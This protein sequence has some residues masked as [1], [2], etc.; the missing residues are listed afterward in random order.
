MSDNTILTSRDKEILRDEVSPDGYADFENRMAKIRYRV[1]R[2][3][4]ALAEEVNLL[5]DAGETAVVDEFCQ[6]LTEEVHCLEHADVE[7]RLRRIEK[8]LERIESQHS[9]IESLKSEL[10]EVRNEL[11]IPI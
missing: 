8:D 1:R 7:K 2:R 11:D 6:T 3:S 4:Q 10:D 5:I 9:D